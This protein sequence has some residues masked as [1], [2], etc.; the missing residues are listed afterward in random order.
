V[1]FSETLTAKLVSQGRPPARS[2]IGINTGRVVVGNIGARNHFNY[3]VMGDEANLASRLEGANKLYGTRIM[4][5]DA[6]CRKV[7]DE[8]LV[9][10]LDTIRVKGKAKPT[11]VFEV[12]DAP[13]QG[14]DGRLRAALDHF[15]RGLLE[16][17]QR[18]WQAALAAFES[19]REIIPS[20]GPAAAY[21]E[22]CR[23]FLAHPPGPDWDGVLTLKNK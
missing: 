11:T 7:K 14:G 22:R 2:R 1:R 20:D 9:R 4:I 16:Y 12:L 23:H 8:F 6:T 18:N 21:E 3:T 17:R 13:R 15:S 10:E 5:S 19:A